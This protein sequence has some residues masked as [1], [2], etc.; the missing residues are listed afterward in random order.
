MRKNVNLL[1]LVLVL[2]VLLSIV[3]LTTYYQS[4]FKNISETYETTAEELSKISKNFTTKLTELNRTTT[5]LSVK[6]TD[7]KKLEELYNRLKAE[8]D[9][10]YTEL[11]AT[12][13]KLA[14]TTVLLEQTE[15]ELSDAKYD[16]LK[17]DIEIAD[18]DSAVTNQK[19]RINALN[20]DI[21]S[22][23]KQINPDY[24]C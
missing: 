6:S 13:E 3:L 14:S 2:I 9:K 11:T 15:S 24:T 4:N 22:L 7:K 5:E 20:D 1:M 17:K 8:R 23:N 16:I 21:C 10:L 19:N 18:L 12:Q